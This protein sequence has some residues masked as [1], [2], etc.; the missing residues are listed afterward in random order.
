[1]FAMPPSTARIQLPQMGHLKREKPPFL[2]LFSL[3]PSSYPL[4][5]NAAGSICRKTSLRSA[6]HGKN[7]Y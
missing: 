6:L 7:I 3:F 4:F 2:L 1:M 5:P